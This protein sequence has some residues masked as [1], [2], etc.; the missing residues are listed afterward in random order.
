M[1]VRK[2][3][4]SLFSA[5]ARAPQAGCSTPY[6]HFIANVR[7]ERNRYALVCESQPLTTFRSHG[8][9]AVAPAVPKSI[10]RRKRMLI[11][12][13]NSG[14]TIGWRETYFSKDESVDVSV[15]GNVSAIMTRGRTTGKVD[16]KTFVGRPLMPSD[17]SDG[18]K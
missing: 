10:S 9:F 15:V 17:C 2:L 13:D 18:K 7:Q 16:T 3:P 4:P 8:T 12:K 5:K 6:L 11:S 14:K 1:A